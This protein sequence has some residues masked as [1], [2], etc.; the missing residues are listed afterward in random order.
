MRHN[1]P[2]NPDM[3][4]TKKQLVREIVDLRTKLIDSEHALNIKHLSEES[5]IEYFEQYAG[6]FEP[7]PEAI[8]LLEMNG[9]ILN[10]ND[11]IFG[12]L[13]YHPDEIIG[14]KIFDLSF[15]PVQ[16]NETIRLNFGKRLNGER[17]LPYDIELITRNGE[18]RIGRINATLLTDVNDTKISVMVL[19]S[20]VTDQRFRE[21]EKQMLYDQL[22]ERVNRNT[23]ELKKAYDEITLMNAERSRMKM[24]M[25]SFREQI[26]YL[27]SI[28]KT[29]LDNIDS[30]FN[31]LYIDHK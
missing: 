13:G 27:Y 8:L 25:T 12:W 24:E 16:S 5:L 10:M 30:D 7:I 22:E 14:K 18:T 28:T 6:I 2:V 20:D 23:V 3:R 1:M 29:D 15:I 26:E 17:I 21:E 11:G 9:V 4:K 19:L 31:I